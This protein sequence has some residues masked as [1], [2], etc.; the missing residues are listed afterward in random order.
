MTT[1][2]LEAKDVPAVIRGS[3]KGSKFQA[4]VTESVSIP[5]DAGLY[6]GGS[7]NAYQAIDLNTGE[8]AGLSFAASSPWDRDRHNAEVKLSPGKVIVQSIIFQGKDMGLRIF[9]HPDNAAKL[10][11]A[12][13]IDLTKDQLLVLVATKT[14]KASYNGQDRYDMAKSDYRCKRM[15]E[16]FPSRDDWNVAKNDLIIGGYLNKAGAITVKGKNAAASAA[17]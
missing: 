9:V 14:F 17:A 1:I 16:T 6:S 2:Y 13:A 4:V 15:V 12:P 7:R 5:A 11:P 8:I 3:Y 10:L